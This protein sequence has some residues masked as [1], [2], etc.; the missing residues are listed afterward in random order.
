MNELHLTNKK[1]YQIYYFSENKGWV[2]VG[3]YYTLK[4]AY[5]ELARRMKPKDN[6]VKARYRL[7]K[8]VETYNPLEINV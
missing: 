5:A 8:H 4:G 2:P 1:T 3:D 7:F 6:S